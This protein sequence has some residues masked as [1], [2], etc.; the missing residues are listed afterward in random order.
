MAKIEQAPFRFETSRSEKESLQL[1]PDAKVFVTGQRELKYA[2][3]PSYKI[4][5]EDITDI[6]I[7]CN[8][9]STP[10]TASFTIVAPRHDEFKYYNKGYFFISTMLEVKIYM[11]G[12]FLI[13]EGGE[14]KAPY[15][16]VFWGI[17]TSVQKSYTGGNL[18]INVECADML[19][20]FELTRCNIN[21]TATG[22]F[23]NPKLQMNA[24]TKIFGNKTPFEI[25]LEL[26][27]VTLYNLQ[28][29]TN[30]FYTTQGSNV[31]NGAARVIMEEQSRQLI[32]FWAK[33]FE[34]IEKSMSII[35]YN[36]STKQL[37]K[38]VPNGLDSNILHETARDGGGVSLSGDNLLD[39]FQP[40][41]QTGQIGLYGCETQSHLE[42]INEIRDKIDFEF[43]QDTNGS[44]VFKPRFYNMDVR[45]YKNH[46]IED[47]DI[48]N[49]SIIEN[50]NEIV[51]AMDVRG[52]IDN[53]MINN[54]SEENSI[55]AR[56]T[57]YK[58]ARKYGLR[59]QERYSEY[60]R[61]AKQAFAYAIS[62]LDRINSNAIQGNI[63]IMGRPEIRVGYPMHIVTQDMFI[64]VTA[65]QHSFNYGGT[66]TTSITFNSI[67]RRYISDNEGLNQLAFD[68]IYAPNIVIK[69]NKETP[70]SREEH[71]SQRTNLIKK[72]TIEQTFEK[73][74]NAPE[75]HETEQSKSRKKV[76]R[77]KE[78]DS[79]IEV[80]ETVSTGGANN[81]PVMEDTDAK[82]NTADIEDNKKSIISIG[83]STEE[84][85]GSFSGALSMT[86]V[87]ELLQEM[88][89]VSDSDGYELTGTFPYGSSLQIDTYG[90]VKLK[91]SSTPT[92][93]EDEYLK[94]LGSLNVDLNYGVEDVGFKNSESTLKATYMKGED[95][96]GEKEKEQLKSDGESAFLMFSV[97][98]E[99]KFLVNMEPDTE[100]KDA[101]SA[102]F[103]KGIF[104]ILKEQ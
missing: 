24:Y 51:T 14:L 67:R 76:I 38:K 81:N 23:Y 56:Y 45:R 103:A 86:K 58:L 27:K 22:L 34:Q 46:V 73:N 4:P 101:P 1:A 3:E 79:L 11:K 5:E 64:Y 100:E 69:I 74:K 65:V 41:A 66:F 93:N 59:V 99:A 71:I 57:D 70:A 61:E 52:V 8:M 31:P 89:P 40:Y 60:L 39:K 63:T 44:I 75:L 19:R 104:R 96:Q 33:R 77:D 17:I 37:E 94:E 28:N 29:P 20:W 18:T 12:R 36:G 21:P 80:E 84:Q 49:D 42:I 30:P 13:N 87:I 98:P 97:N 54:P 55:Y 2:G 9:F 43:F 26:T 95:P 25:I 85:N 68:T 92:K 83:T 35:G 7:S 78:S 10:G 102:P 48:I 15:Y 72:G 62:E 6:S 50:E 90:M 16:V 88:I 91:D 82:K 47:I 32:E 53:T